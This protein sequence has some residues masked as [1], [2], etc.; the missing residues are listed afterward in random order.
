MQP[1]YAPPFFGQR[2]TARMQ[3]FCD[4]RLTPRAQQNR[5]MNGRATHRR[6]YMGVT[7]IELLFSLAL[8]ALLAGLAAPGFRS[9]FRAAAVRS[10]AFELAMG[11]QQVRANSIIEARSGLLCPTDSGGRCLAAGAQASGWRT[12]LEDGATRRELA[13]Q[14]LPP[15]VTLRAT[16]SPIRFWPA[17]Y[18]ASA[19]TLTICDEQGVA[20]PRAIV[21]S[22]GGRARLDVSG[23]GACA[24]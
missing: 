4:C 18:A 24:S 19:G 8:L 22:A 16:R 5:L 10:A 14:S 17:A 23:A 1:V 12:F 7:L 13:G 3:Q 6:G 20:P 9:G 2:E 21:I 11:L 15:G